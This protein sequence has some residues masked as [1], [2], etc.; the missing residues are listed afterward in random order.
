MSTWVASA[1]ISG[2]QSLNIGFPS[3]KTPL[4][5]RARGLI[6]L[7]AGILQHHLMTKR[8]VR[9]RLRNRALLVAI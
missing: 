8:D 1:S 3:C 9:H 4:P 5:I 7:T 6:D 2:R